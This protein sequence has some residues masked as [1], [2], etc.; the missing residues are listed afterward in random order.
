MSTPSATSATD[1]SST[2][3]SV[4]P[5]ASMASNGDTTTPKQHSNKGEFR[6]W[7][8]ASRVD[9]PRGLARA[10]Y[11]A[12][13]MARQAEQQG[14]GS[15]QWLVDMASDVQEKLDIHAA[16]KQAQATA[17]KASRKAIDVSRVSES[18]TKAV[19]QACQEIEEIA[20]DLDEDLPDDL[21][22]ELL[23]GYDEARTNNM[24]VQVA[25]TELLIK[26]DELDSAEEASLEASKALVD[27]ASMLK[28]K[29]EGADE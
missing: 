10:V 8:R 2:D 19:V 22:E 4:T 12:C 9:L 27:A 13:A 11:E 23:D 15:K 25:T 3:H 14:D 29:E 21:W 7:L 6:A 17:L 1:S 18:R 24:A 16:A 20:G 5:P 26:R 28:E